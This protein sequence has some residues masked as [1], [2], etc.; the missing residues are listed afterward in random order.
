MNWL[1]AVSKLILLMA[2]SKLDIRMATYN[3]RG[4]NN[5]KKQYIADLLTSS[6]FLL[7]QEHWLSDD[8]IASM[9][10]ISSD[11]LVQGVAGFGNSEILAGRPY[12]GCC[13]FWRQN[14]LGTMVTVPTSSRRICAVIFSNNFFRLLI[15][16]VYMPFEDGTTRVDDFCDQL[17]AI[18]H[19]IEQNQDC[20]VVLAGDFNV[21]FSRPSTHGPILTSFCQ[22]NNMHPAMSH[23]NCN[24]DYTYHFGMSRFSI[25]DHFIVSEVI[26]D[27]SVSSVSCLHSVDNLSD[28]EPVVIQLQMPYNLL[29]GA[30]KSFV[31][32][33]AWYKASSSHIDEYRRVLSNKLHDISLPVDVITCKDML[34]CSPSHRSALNLFMN[35]ITSACLCAANTTIPPTKEHRSDEG[36]PSWNEEIKPLRDKSIFWHNIWVSCG[37]PHDGVVANIMRRTRAFYHCAVRKLKRDLDCATSERFASALLASNGSRDYWSE[38]KRIR[39]HRSTVSATV[40]GCSGALDIAGHFA[41]KYEDLY[42]CVSY[43]QQDMDS[44]RCSLSDII[45]L[46]NFDN[47]CVVISHVDVAAAVQHLK[48]G[49]GDGNKGLS[50]DHILLGSSELFVHL[51]MLLTSA[52]SHGYAP[53]DLLHSSII[54][55]PKGKTCNKTDSANYRGIALSSVVGKILDNVIIGRFGDLL[56]TSELQFGFKSGKS[57]NMCTMVL[58]ETISYYI[59]NGSRMYCTMLD[60]S[61]AFDRVE[62]CKLFRLLIARN[63]PPIIIRFLLD[64]YTRHVSSVQWNGVSSGT[65]C[66]QNGVKQGGVLSPVLFCIYFDNLLNNLAACNTGCYMGKCFVGALA[67]ADDLVLLAPSA[68]AMRSLL[69]ICDDFG[70][71]FNVIFNASKSKCMIIQPRFPV[72]RWLRHSDQPLFTIGGNVIEIVDQWPHLGHIITNKFDDEADISARRFSM[73]GQINNVLCYFSSINSLHRSQLLYAYCS[74]YYG[75]EL[76]DLSH[77]SLLTFCSAWRK[78]IRRAWRLPNATHCNLLPLLC[79]TRSIEDELCC[80]VLNFIS[81]CLHSS[82]SIVSYVTRYALYHGMQHSPIGRNAA[83]CSNKLKINPVNIVSSRSAV[84]RLKQHLLNAS[85]LDAPKV[86]FLFELLMI[87]DGILSIDNFGKDNLTSL[88]DNLCLN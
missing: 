80:R 29:A 64:L 72:A 77:S 88:I 11:H 16:N 68:R 79:G 38:V 21:D 28:H 42:S 43:D 53:D 22:T 76:W 78:G 82:C 57:T 26:F 58:K 34:C 62:Y 56:S 37:R 46:S 47:N 39:S 36:L 30:T 24:V 5:L 8:Q 10:E 9:G 85:I 55:I 59:N 61:K 73:I 49:K 3:C 32:K 23:T 63:F 6:D 13:I 31:H 35:D 20:H 65:F 44:I 25:L 2:Q 81:S 14:L 19:L 70:S 48:P 51:A 33:P 83:Y 40:D 87:R 54:P 60:V 15:I 66:V 1:L 7:V 4:Y 71:Q 74:S 41:K 18:D 27:S 12:G 45:S 67:Y 17:S 50:S 75:C 52:L 86:L 69:S 84:S